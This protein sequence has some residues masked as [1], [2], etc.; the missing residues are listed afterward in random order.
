MSKEIIDYDRKFFAKNLDRISK[1]YQNEIRANQNR[2][3]EK[4]IEYVEKNMF[5]AREA[6]NTEVQQ[7]LKQF[8]KSGD[9]VLNMKK[10]I[11]T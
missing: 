10:L 11:K 4:A 2:A 1:S 5:N 9:D 6:L 8:N 7:L 3:R